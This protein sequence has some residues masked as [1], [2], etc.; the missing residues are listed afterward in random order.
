MRR[1]SEWERRAD[2]DGAAGLVQGQ[3]DVV[4]VGRQFQKNPATVWAFAEDL[5]VKIT[6][7]HQIEWGFGGRGKVGRRAQKL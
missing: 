1:W 3:A 2:A 5:G 6:V 4:F 7:A